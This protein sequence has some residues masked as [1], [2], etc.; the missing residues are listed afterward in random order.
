MPSAIGQ[1]LRIIRRFKPHLVLGVGSYASGPV[2][3]AAWMSGKPVV[4]HEQNL[5]PGITNRTLARLARRIYVSFDGTT[6]RFP[7]AKVRLTGNPVRREI[8][9][10][11]AERKNDTGGQPDRSPVLNI[12]IVGGSQGAHAVN[13]AVADALPL[14]RQKQRLRFVHQTGA[15]DEDHLRS[16]Y[17][18]AG[19]SAVVGA[20]FDDMHRQYQRADVIICRAG[21]TTVAEITAVG[22]AAIFIPFPFAADDHQKHNAAALAAAGAAEI[23]EERQLSAAALAERIERFAK[24]RRLLGRMAERARQFGRPEAARLLVDDFCAVIDGR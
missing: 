8:L 21:A 24:D 1:S 9:Q 11:A 5:L 15:A 10:P 18:A 22:R 17:T 14:L 6:G 23:I 3:L 7:A 13:M 19:V 20:F 16:A 12:L 4:L 2:V